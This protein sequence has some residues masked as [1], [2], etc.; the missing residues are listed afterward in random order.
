[1]HIRISVLVTTCASVVALAMIVALAVVWPTLTW[2]RTTRE[3]DNAFLKRIESRRRLQASE[4]LRCEFAHPP[5]ANEREHYHVYSLPRVTIK[6]CNVYFPLDEMRTLDVP[7]A[8]SDENPSRC[9]SNRDDGCDTRCGHELTEQELEE[10]VSPFFAWLDTR[11]NRVLMS[12]TLLI[13][14]NGVCPPNLCYRTCTRDD[15]RSCG[16]SRACA[17]FG[18][19][20]GARVSKSKS[21]EE[22]FGRSTEYDRGH[23]VSSAAMQIFYGQSDLSFTM[24]NVAPQTI[25]LN[26][27]KWLVVER[28]VQM[29]AQERPQV[30]EYSGSMWRSDEDVI[31]SEQYKL[32]FVDTDA[33]LWVMD[34]DECGDY[35]DDYLI[36]FH[37]LDAALEDIR[38]HSGVDFSN[39]VSTKT[40]RIR[41]TMEIAGGVTFSYPRDR[42]G[43][44]VY[45]LTR[46]TA[47]GLIDACKCEPSRGI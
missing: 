30:F 38:T 43:D 41:D 25:A 16:A 28:F 9:F 5:T 21:G 46:G 10:N 24:C 45:D 15:P 44:C 32:V 23:L 4:A 35:K 29:L 34:N 6:G 39:I 27:C 13:G 1:M 22:I 17:R 3:C 26:Q 37:K 33:Y 18:Q 11:R 8:M 42:I 12:A 36:P 40:H 47:S 19:C 20:A 31:P 7:F 2:P 14:P